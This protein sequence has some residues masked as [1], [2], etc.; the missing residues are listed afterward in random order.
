MRSP[1]RSS[2]ATAVQVACVSCH[3]AVNVRGNMYQ[4]HGIFPPLASPEPE[5]VRVPSV[6]NVGVTPPHFDDGS[7]AALPPRW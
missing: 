2:P 3:Q 6:R 4:R 1:Q 7:A 5:I